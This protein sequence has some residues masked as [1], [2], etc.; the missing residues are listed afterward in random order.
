MGCE[1][2]K[3]LYDNIK[4]V[5]EIRRSLYQTELSLKDFTLKWLKNQRESNKIRLW[6]KAAKTTRP[7]ELYGV[8][9]CYQ[10]VTT[11]NR[12]VIKS[13]YKHRWNFVGD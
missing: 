1:N 10:Y 5:W 6:R 12:L 7:I 4:S 9:D 2:K 11:N 3:L 8:M 13:K